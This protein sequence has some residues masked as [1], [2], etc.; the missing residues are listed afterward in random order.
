MGFF[1]SLFGSSDDSSD[2]SVDDPSLDELR[3]GYML[4]YEMRTW[5]VTKHAK[6]DYEGWPADEWTL[7]NNDDLLFLEYEYDDGD[8]FLLSEP[9]DITDVTADG[10]S[11]RVV[12]R[13][14]EPP[15]TVMHDGTEYVL[16]E[17]GP[18]TRTVDNRTNK[19]RYW[20]YE[21]GDDFV[22]LERYGSSDWNVYVGREVEPYEF[23]NILPR[24]SS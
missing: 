18:A 22:A 10:E 20:V 9:A 21:H 13:D 19:L 1:D 6:Y 23:D 24:A 2:E 8:V 17:E 3:E 7:E 11:F 16:A 12:L 14:S 15:G 4:D 5:E